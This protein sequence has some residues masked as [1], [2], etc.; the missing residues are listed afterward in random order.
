MK[1]TREKIEVMEAYERGEKIDVYSFN[2]GALMTLDNSIPSWNW[3]GYD[4]RIKPK[5]EVKRWLWAIRDT[6]GRWR[7]SEVFFSEHDI[8][9][10]KP[11][12]VI[13]IES[14]M[15]EVDE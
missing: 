13:K 12:H 5:P 14:S 2:D 8:R 4:Y 15:I 7:P 3:E 10:F 6:E 9:I 11:S 1:T